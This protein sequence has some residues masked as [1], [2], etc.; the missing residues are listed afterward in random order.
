MSISIEQPAT[1]ALMRGPAMPTDEVRPT[2]ATRRPAVPWDLLTLAGLLGGLVALQLLDSGPSALR[3]LVALPVLFF[4]P[5]YALSLV[6]FARAGQLSGAERLG[7]SLALSLAV[8]VFSG[9]GLF[10]AGVPINGASLLIGLGGSLAALLLAAAV[11]R[12]ALPASERFTPWP[13]RVAP[14]RWSGGDRLTAL[15]IAALVALGG[16][17]LGYTA[18]AA[19]P[20][21]YYTALAVQG[22]AS[23]KADLPLTVAGSTFYPLTVVVQNQEA[24]AQSY[25]LRVADGDLTIETIPIPALGQGARWEQQLSIPLI[26]PTT[27]HR[28]SLELYRVGDALP[29]RELHLWV[30]QAGSG[31]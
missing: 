2:P 19:A 4:A 11:R 22:T 8:I 10:W 5:G 21:E 31:K 13:G 30:D 6:L 9:L 27:M 14:A 24:A 17:A 28:L 16:A 1:P 26:A 18:V 15:G 25:T 3:F 7:L 20:G 23:G 12:H 29:Y